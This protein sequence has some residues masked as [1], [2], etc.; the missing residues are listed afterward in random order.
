MTFKMVY[1]TVGYT[2]QVLDLSPTS[3]IGGGGEIP[4]YVKNYLRL[5]KQNVP[6]PSSWKLREKKRTIKAGGKGSYET[7]CML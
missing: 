7:S 3:L 6:N 2:I 1:H 4:E 5:N